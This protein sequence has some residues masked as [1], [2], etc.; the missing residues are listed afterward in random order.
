MKTYHIP[1]TDL[2][3]SRIAYGCMQIGGNWT[4]DPLSTADRRHAERAIQTALDVGITLFDHADIYT[5]GKSETVFGEVLGANPSLRHQIV[6]QTKCGIIFSDDVHPGRY[7]FSYA[8]IT[9]AVESSLQRLQ[10]DVIDILLLHRPDPLVEPEEVAHAFDELQAAG[11]VRYFGVSN[12][13]PWQI[14][15]LQKNVRQPLVVNQLE[16]NLLHNHMIDEG[17]I[18]NQQAISTNLSSAILDYCRLK[19]ILVQAWAPLANGILFDQDRLTTP[20]LQNTSALVSQMAQVKGVSREAILLAWLLRHP[21][22]IQPVI[23]STKPERIQ[24]A[25]QADDITLTRED[26]YS[27]YIAARGNKVP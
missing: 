5:L 24:A 9:A 21:A 6:L 25:C 3:V 10:T 1:R 7:D 17:I 11:K 12:H 18:A 13:T 2:E 19:E 8:H 4:A 14:D 27:L 23:G 20:F 22:G 26:W 16:L 15:L